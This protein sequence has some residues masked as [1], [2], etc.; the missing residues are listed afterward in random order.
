[1][2]IAIIGAGIGG[3]TTAIFLE[4]LGI[5]V[6]VYEQA[7]EIKPVGAG[8]I[9]VPLEEARFSKSERFIIKAPFFI[10][11]CSL[12]KKGNA[13]YDLLSLTQGLA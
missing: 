10:K 8:I 11:G 6:H 4:K 3:L 7:K 13:G 5:N 9:P 2:D 12:K 1:M